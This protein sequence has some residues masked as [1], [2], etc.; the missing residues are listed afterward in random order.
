MEYSR[1]H[2]WTPFS[3]LRASAELFYV[4]TRESTTKPDDPCT[5]SPV[6]SRTPGEL[7]GENG[8]GS[9]V[10][11]SSTQANRR[12]VRTS[13]S[14]AKGSAGLVPEPS[15]Q[16]G[17]ER[18]SVIKGRRKRSKSGCVAVVKDIPSRSRVTQKPNEFTVKGARR[19]DERAIR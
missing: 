15:R 17:R 6:P 3:L 1:Q 13:G 18:E 8:E 9:V 16:R 12:T 2:I 4:A 7:F 19:E 5:L 10:R 11:R 14:N